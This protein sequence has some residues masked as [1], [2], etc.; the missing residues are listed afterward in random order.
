MDILAG[1]KTQGKISGTL[2]FANQ[3]PTKTFLRRYTGYVEQFDVLL[4]SLTVKEML[5]YTAELKVRYPN[6]A[7]ERRSRTCVK[8]GWRAETNEREIWCEDAESGGIDAQN[9]SDDLEG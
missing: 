7:R 5:I 8:F 2:L 9:E 3:K 6:G 1:R 4:E